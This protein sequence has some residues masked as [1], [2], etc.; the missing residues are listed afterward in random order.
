MVKMMGKKKEILKEKL[1]KE[2]G[3]EKGEEILNK[4]TIAW[5]KDLSEGKGG[6]GLTSKYISDAK[7]EIRKKEKK[8]A[9][10]LRKATPLE[11]PAP[12]KKPSWTKANLAEWQGLWKETPI[13]PAKG[14]LEKEVG[15]KEMPKWVNQSITLAKKSQNKL[16]GDIGSLTS[17]NKET[18]ELILERDSLEKR[19]KEFSDDARVP[20]TG[21]IEKINVRK[22]QVQG[23]IERKS[24]RGEEIIERIKA[25]RTKLNKRIANIS[26]WREEAKIPSKKEG[27]AETLIGDLKEIKSKMPLGKSVLEQVEKYSERIDKE[28]KASEEAYDEIKT[29][30]QKVKSLKERREEIG[31]EDEG[32]W[33]AKK[34][35][36]IPFVQKRVHEL[37]RKI[38]EL[39]PEIGRRKENKRKVDSGLSA[40]KEE[41]ENIK[42][43]VYSWKEEQEKKKP[44]VF[45]ISPE[46]IKEKAKEIITKAQEKASLRGTPIPNYIKAKKMAEK[47]L[48]REAEKLL[49]SDLGGALKFI[50][51]EIKKPVKEGRKLQFKL[52][53]DLEE[54]KKLKENRER[55][56]IRESLID[57]DLKADRS[58]GYDRQTRGAKE[59]NQKEIKKALKE[60]K[61]GGKMQEKE[62]YLN[63]EIIKSKKQLRESVKTYKEWASRKI[64]EGKSIPRKEKEE[65]EEVWRKEQKKEFRKLEIDKLKKRI[66]TKWEE[67]LKQKEGKEFRKIIDRTIKELEEEMA[68]KLQE[69]TGKEQEK[70]RKEIYE[71]LKPLFDK[72]NLSKERKDKMRKMW[73][74]FP[75]EE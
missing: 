3:E 7:E 25:R 54:L 31:I 9:E 53:R 5:K 13:P 34:G 57:S 59:T 6:L 2:A 21:E 8:E 44:S 70:T 27:D 26:S 74:N 72:L 40:T 29:L 39:E 17:L 52:K 15:K 24:T 50:P 12:P 60:F 62:E 32:K 33:K 35:T 46:E 71:E 38:K 10:E 56:E 19:L 68:E 48:D 45:P 69:E 43:D 16:S 22:E 30:E 67:V 18:L 63:K 66:K 47:E 42:K 58:G 14:E 20:S 55:L 36:G 49:T 64:Q 28:T 37:T 75:K 41:L 51:S 11:R 65:R 73:G 61:T 23:E 4:A 1:K